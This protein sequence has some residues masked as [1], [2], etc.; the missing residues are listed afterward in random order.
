MEPIK[1][2]TNNANTITTTNNNAD[3]ATQTDFI[4]NL[5]M[6]YDVMNGISSHQ[7]SNKV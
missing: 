3:L 4:L 5:L 7:S 1:Y 2:N 6:C